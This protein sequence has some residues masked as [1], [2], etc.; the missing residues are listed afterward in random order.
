MLNYNPFSLQTRQQILLIVNIVSQMYLVPAPSLAADW[1]I[2]REAFTAQV[3][4]RQLQVRT[5]IIL[6]LPV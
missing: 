2:P 6:E 4:Y 1:A 3:L 5:T